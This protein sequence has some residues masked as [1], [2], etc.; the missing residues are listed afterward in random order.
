MS[1]VVYTARLGARGDDLK[2]P[3]AIP[4][5]RFIAFSEE[6]VAGWETR[7]PA[8]LTGNPR[9][10]ARAHKCLAHRLFPDAE[11][12]LWM[13]AQY[14]PLC[15][16]RAYVQQATDAGAYDFCTYKHANRVCLYQEVR[17]CAALGKDSP[18][19]LL[20][21]GRRYNAEGY[22]YFNGLCETGIV[23]R[24]NTPSVQSLNELWW[25]EISRGSCRDQISLPYVLWKLRRGY[26]QLP[27]QAML[28]PYGFSFRP[29]QASGL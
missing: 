26:K 25:N 10:T 6:P 5:V 11:Y 13:D 27:G 22:P 9:V 7:A 24:R 29:Y 4:G 1:L 14:Q 19:V 17:A 16:L 18:D 2:A 12:T 28:R 8:F 15:D 21:Q 20:A 3:P 23:V